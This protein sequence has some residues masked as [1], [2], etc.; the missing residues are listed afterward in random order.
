MSHHEIDP[1]EPT[2]WCPQ[3]QSVG[4]RRNV[5]YSEPNDVEAPKNGPQKELIVRFAGDVR[6]KNH[7]LFLRFWTD[8][9]KAKTMIFRTF[10]KAL[11]S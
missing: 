8:S 4:C 1:L 5:T 11:K 2:Q 6:Q 10:E 3:M 7:P 9:K